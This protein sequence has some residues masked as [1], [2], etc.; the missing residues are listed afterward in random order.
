MKRMRNVVVH[1]YFD[2]DIETV[3]RTIHDDLPPLETALRRIVSTL[4]P[5]G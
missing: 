2:V 5:E 1:A 3:W 4:P